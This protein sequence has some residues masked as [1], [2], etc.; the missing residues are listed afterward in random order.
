MDSENH[1]LRN[2]IDP[3][4]DQDG[5]RNSLELIKKERSNTKD[6]DFGEKS[7]N[8]T[9]VKKKMKKNNNYPRYPELSN[10]FEGPEQSLSGPRRLEPLND[11]Y[12]GNKN[13]IWGSNQCPIIE[14]KLYKFTKRKW[15]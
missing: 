5:T 6:E 7:E 12:L 10:D 2:I 9:Q 4:N 14:V 15:K 11:A 13:Y 3:L 8:E 1:L